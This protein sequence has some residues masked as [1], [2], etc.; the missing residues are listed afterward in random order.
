MLMALLVACRCDA[1]PYLLHVVQSDLRRRAHQRGGCGAPR[2]DGGRWIDSNA[3]GTWFLTKCSPRRHLLPQVDSGSRE[4]TPE[5]R[6]KQKLEETI[7]ALDKDGDGSVSKEEFRVVFKVSFPSQPFEPVWL[8]IDKNGDG[9]LTVHE[10][11]E[12]YGMGHLFEPTS[13]SPSREQSR[14]TTSAPDG[15]CGGVEPKSPDVGAAVMTSV[16]K[17]ND[18]CAN[19][20]A[21]QLE[22]QAMR[23]EMAALRDESISR[24]E[25]LREQLERLSSVVA[26]LPSALKRTKRRHSDGMREGP[27]SRPPSSTCPGGLRGE[28]PSSRVAGMSAS[29]EA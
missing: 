29:Y 11:A 25:R 16:A 17:P 10:I 6:E 12:Y 24:E 21:L 18:L 2:E 8:D 15:G 22:L 9:E 26:A 4:L 7:R 13:K 5:E 23:S 20:A 28:V 1:S 14:S 19:V 3:P 27:N